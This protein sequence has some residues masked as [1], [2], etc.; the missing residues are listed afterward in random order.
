MKGLNSYDA[1]KHHFTSLKNDLISGNLVVLERKFSWNCSENNSIF[2]LFFTFSSTTSRELD[3]NSRLVVDEN[4]NGKFR[5]Q[6]V[7]VMLKTSNNWI[8]CL[9]LLVVYMTAALYFYITV[10]FYTFF[11]YMNICMLCLSVSSR[12]LWWYFTYLMALCL[13]F[14][15]WTFGKVKDLLTVGLCLHHFVCWITF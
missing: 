13:L 7:K 3:S 8:C 6:R 11:K 10:I 9:W 4:D 1:L 2:F 15:L 12:K 5:L 14:R